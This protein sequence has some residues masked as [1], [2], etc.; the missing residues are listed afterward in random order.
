MQHELWLRWVPRPQW[1]VGSSPHMPCSS[2]LVAGGNCSCAGA[3]SSSSRDSRYKA[4]MRYLWPASSAQRSIIFTPMALCPGNGGTSAATR[5]ESLGPAASGDVATYV[6]AW[7]DAVSIK[8][9]IRSTPVPPSQ[10]LSLS[11]Q[12]LLRSETCLSD[13]HYRRCRSS[14]W[15][16]WSVLKRLMTTPL[17]R[18]S[19]RASIPPSCQCA[20][21]YLDLSRTREVRLRECHCPKF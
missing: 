8:R 16:R 21:T 10:E 12:R 2:R 19:A 18:T 15:G 4:W 6:Y 14:N 5:L 9:D 7:F 3:P 11:H 13:L 1:S 20:S 17:D